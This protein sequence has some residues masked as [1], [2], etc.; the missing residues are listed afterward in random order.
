VAI[1]QAGAYCR[2]MASAYNARP[3]CAE[4]L[5]EGGAYR[6]IREPLPAQELAAR[7]RA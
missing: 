1:G 2:V 7:E 4:V 6:V 3:L 5:L